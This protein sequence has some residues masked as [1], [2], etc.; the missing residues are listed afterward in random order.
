V[1]SEV[2]ALHACYVVSEYYNPHYYLWANFDT[3]LHRRAIGTF[4]LL[5]SD[6]DTSRK[7]SVGHIFRLIF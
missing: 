2:Q 5:D 3:G 6:Y 7:F 4:F 1:I